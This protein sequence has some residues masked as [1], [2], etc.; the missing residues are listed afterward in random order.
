MTNYVTCYFSPNKGAAKAIIGFINRCEHSLDIAVY[1]ITHDE[2]SQ[3]IIDAHKKG[4]K[5]RVITDNLQA[6]NV[7]SDDELL[8]EA[9]IPILK[10]RKAGS[11]HHK[12]V[13]G[14]N[15]AIGTGSFNWTLNADRRNNENFVIIRLKY[16]IKSY[17]KQFDLLWC[18]YSK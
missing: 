9:G 13:I 10:T 18:D 16:V 12:F 5:V 3:A 11:M 4:V 14:D 1:A 7:Y 8:Q 2:I 6:S 15:N 17:Q